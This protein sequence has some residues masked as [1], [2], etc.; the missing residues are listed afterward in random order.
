[1]TSEE[2]L[3]IAKCDDLFSQCDR[4]SDVRF[5]QFLN[6]AEQAVIIKNIGNRIGYNCCF[7]GGYDC[8]QR[9]IFTVFPEWS[10]PCNEEFPIKVLKIVKKFKKE[11]SHRD[12]LGTVLSKGIDR[13]KVGDILIDSDILCN[14]FHYEYICFITVN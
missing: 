14:I 7:Y 6:E 13:N 1:M 12:Y 2:K 5:S 8:A 3:L 10:E 9:K 11:L 4:Y